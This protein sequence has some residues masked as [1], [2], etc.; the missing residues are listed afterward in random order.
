MIGKEEHSKI[1]HYKPSHLQSTNIDEEPD[2][3]WLSEGLPKC[4]LQ[5]P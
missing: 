3:L 4:S 5:G 2:Y 1:D